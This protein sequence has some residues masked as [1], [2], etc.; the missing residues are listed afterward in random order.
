MYIMLNSRFTDLGN[1]LSLRRVAA[2]CAALALLAA[3]SSAPHDYRTLDVQDAVTR[4]AETQQRGDFT[5]SA[6]VPGEAEA[7][8]IFGI[9]TYDRGIQ[10]VWLEVT[11]HSDARARLILASLDR[12]YFS[13]HEVAYLH[14]RQFSKEGLQQLEEHLYLSALPRQI[15][16]GATASGYVFTHAS[17]GTK[18]IN[19]DMFYTTATS[20]FEHFTFFLQVPGFVPDHAE[21]EFATLYQPEE[22]IE[23][24]RAGFRDWL[25]SAPCCTRNRTGLAEGRPVNL[26]I[27]ASGRD[28]LQ[29]LLRA[30]WDETSYPKD[31]RYLDS[32]DHLFGRPPDAI[33]KKG[34]AG[35]QDRNEMGLWL[36]PLRVDGS[37]VWAAQ[38]KHAVGRR[39]DLGNLF[40][41]PRQDPDSNDGRNYVLQDL[42]YNQALRHWAWSR[43]GVAVDDAAPATDFN[44]SPWFAD[45]Y[46]MVLWVAGEPLALTEAT[47]IHWDELIKPGS[48][49]P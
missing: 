45:G 31:A 4:R 7:A 1:R 27:V 20:R 3:C 29:A 10:P 49:R 11:N 24:D 48:A 17:E 37:T 26:F 8:S 38:V 30:G 28:L 23:L 14:K 44:G 33:V 47:Q 25:E 13:P 16:A 39:F 19:V 42:W 46:R 40:F 36:T 41:A 32:A 2:A 9:P 21:V 15:A 43:T 12:Q 35:Q 34:R 5:V 6:S 18:A 22:I